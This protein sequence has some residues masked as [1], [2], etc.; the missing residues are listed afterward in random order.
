MSSLR[1]ISDVS[2]TLACVP[3]P[4]LILQDVEPSDTIEIMAKKIQTATDLL[5][6]NSR[7][8]ERM[9]FHVDRL[10]NDIV[11]IQKDVENKNHKLTYKLL[12]TLPTEIKNK[13]ML[14]TLKCPHDIVTQ[15][16][17]NWVD[18]SGSSLNNHH[19]YEIATYSPRTN[20]YSIITE[21]KFGTILRNT[22]NA[23]EYENYFR[24]D[25]EEVWIHPMKYWRRDTYDGTIVS[26]LHLFNA[27]KYPWFTS[28]Y[29]IPLYE[30]KKLA[31]MNKIVGRSKL[32][33]RED[34]IKAFMKL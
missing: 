24:W 6:Y 15:E 31:S 12:K 27:K 21:T 11:I 8:L 17:P 13:I 14:Y 9:I 33:T 34:Y 7:I 30:L 23:Q 5:N 2:Q 25:R 10:K 3:S 18:Y 29:L 1:I 28:Q 32:K 19:K 20:S 22:K 4:R 16:L 26:N